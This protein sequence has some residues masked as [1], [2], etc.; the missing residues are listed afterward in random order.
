MDGKETITGRVDLPCAATGFTPPPCS[1]H[2]RL[3]P[4]GDRWTLLARTAPNT[5]TVTARWLESHKPSRLVPGPGI[6]PKFLRAEY[7]HLPAGL[8]RLVHAVQLHHIDIEADGTA[9]LFT[10]GPPEPA[11][12]LASQLRLLHESVRY[13]PAA[14]GPEKAVLTPRQMEAI[15]T[16]VALGYYEIPRHLDLRTLGKAMEVSL[17]SVSELLR[18]AE[19]TIVKNYVDSIASERWRRLT[20]EE[21]ATSDRSQHDALS[22]WF[23]GARPATGTGDVVPRYRTSR[24]STSNARRG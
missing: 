15:S 23:A 22:P 2:L 19:G 21:T 24:A 16:A 3:V 11:Q 6:A 7:D 17:G 10:T 9:S 18:R 13:R 8:E 12:R 4:D 1:V 5:P 20:P 14:V